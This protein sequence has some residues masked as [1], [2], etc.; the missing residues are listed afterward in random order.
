MGGDRYLAQFGLQ[1]IPFGTEA[2][3]IP[4]DL[5]NVLMAVNIDEIGALPGTNTVPI[6]SASQQLQETIRHITNAYKGMLVTDP[7]PASNHYDFYT[8]HIPTMAL[9]SIGMTNLIHH[10]RDTIEWVSYAK[11]EE[12]VEFVEKVVVEIQ[13]KSLAWARNQV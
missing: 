4:S 1:V 5:D 8:H 6:M 12:V 11:V 13:D 3:H 10:E 9:N 7:W 2:Q